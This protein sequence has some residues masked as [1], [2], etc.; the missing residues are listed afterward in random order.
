MQAGTRGM[1]GWI[2]PDDNVRPDHDC[3]KLEPW[4]KDRGLDGVR[5]AVATSPSSGIHQAD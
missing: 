3:Y 2:K 5:T 1:L 4:L